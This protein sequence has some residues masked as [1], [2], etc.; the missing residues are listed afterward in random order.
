MAFL[1]NL[2]ATLTGL[3]I[4]S[5]I[6]FFILAGVLAVASSNEIP[7]VEPDT[8]ISL[9]LSGILVEKAVE[10]PLLEA[11][12]KLPPQISLLDILSAIDAAKEDDRV[13][14]MYLKPMYLEAGYAMLQEI[15]D[16]IIDFKSS[17]K[18]VYAY[19]DYISESDLYIASTADSLFV[20]PTGGL[21]FNGL[22]INITFLKG[23]FEK[24][25]IEPEVFR[26][27][28][29]KSYVEP[30]IRKNMSDENRLQY[31][32]LLN[33]I[34]GTY[35][36]NVSASL[37]KNVEELERISNFMEVRLP[38]DA[39][40]LGLVSKVGYEDELIRVMK[41]K[42]GVEED[43]EL[44]MMPVRRYAKAMAAK[45]KYSA[46]KIA[47]IVAQG[48]IVMSGDKGIVGKRFADEIRKARNNKSVKA[49]VMRVNSGGGSM[50]ASDMIWRELMLTKDVKPVIASM[51]N[52]AA[53]GGYYIAMPADTIVAQ[54][55]TVTGSIGIF[56]M[57]FDLTNF[58]ENKLGITHDVVKTGEFADIYTVTRSLT[59]YERQIIQTMVDEGYGT[60][61]KKAADA[62]GMS[63]DDLKAIASGRV[64]SGEQ[65][66]GNGLV[67]LLG[68][69]NDAVELAAKAA[70]VGNDY[71]VRYYPEQKTFIE[72]VLDNLA[73]SARTQLLG[74]EM[75]PLAEKLQE[76]KHLQGIQARLPGDLQVQ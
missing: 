34:Y 9:D 35:L 41:S 13:K 65:A 69:F 17:G 70:G 4:F 28:E 57:W 63:Q 61:I 14:G 37:G 12:G 38:K 32:S 55:N 71:R 74:M 2:L 59:S 39:A 22:N 19:G 50:T 47:V 21:E 7:E 15:R 46:N 44:K 5:I 48:N 73:V 40:R 76:L 26:V 66:L 33:S 10:N 58:L 16:A 6:C 54:P 64:W 45:A 31:S 36:L 53:S 49:I 42:V 1:R 8:I 60:F 24:L 18:F 72:E 30:Y 23:L 25:E 68:S 20:N 43:K 29:F 75:D 3:V 27:G 52:A 62:R 51:S 11:I 67:D 56:G